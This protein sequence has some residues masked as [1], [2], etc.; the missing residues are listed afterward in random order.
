M[1][2]VAGYRL[3]GHSNSHEFFRGR[4]IQSLKG[5]LKSPTHTPSSFLSYVNAQRPR[6]PFWY[7]YL[8]KP[9]IILELWVKEECCLRYLSINLNYS[10]QCAA[11]T[12]TNKNSGTRSVEIVPEPTQT[13]NRLKQAK[14][15]GLWHPDE[16]HYINMVDGGPPNTLLSNG[17]TASNTH[18][19]LS[20][21]A[22]CQD[23]L[24]C[25]K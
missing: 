25:S 14:A 24:P 12:I 20:P 2:T 6:S 10:Y 11:Q 4:F 17:D 21:L 16:S 1:Q 3:V 8:C 19:G 13:Q 18:Y 5:V 7:P 23:F 9:I 15:E 22:I